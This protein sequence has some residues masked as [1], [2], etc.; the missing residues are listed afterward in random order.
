MDVVV[1][2]NSD[3]D[4]VKTIMADITTFPTTVNI[5]G[6][7]LI[8]LFGEP[9]ELGDRFEFGADITTQN[10][11]FFSAFNPLGNAYGSGVGNQQGAQTSVRYEAVCTYIAADY[12]S[13]PTDF[14]VISDEWADYAPGT[15]IKVNVIDENTLSFQYAAANP[16]DIIIKVNLAS[17]ETSVEKVIYGD[18]GSFTDLAAESVANSADN[19][20]S[21]CEKTISVRLNHSSPAGNFGDATIVLKKV[22]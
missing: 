1:V 19:F 10:D 3:K 6:Q 16:K 4:N 15:V 7:Q 9:I 13:G 22:E 21:P 11:E 8:D 17:N 12:G 14:E 5:T 2:K 18:Y 20:V